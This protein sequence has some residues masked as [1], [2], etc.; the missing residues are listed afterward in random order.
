MRYLL[1]T[2][3]CI[4]LI[5]ER[6]RALSEAIGRHRPADV[7]LSVVTSYE[8]HYGAYRSARMKQNM[9]ALAAFLRPFTIVAF[10]TDDAIK[11]GELRAELER[12]GTPI[13]PYDLLIAAQAA[14]RNVTLVTN[15]VREFARVPG[16]KVEDW[17]EAAEESK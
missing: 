12:R 10:S 8:L 9:Q 6:S 17:T 3:I 11:A 14:T 13:G 1:D 15:N 7:G 4:F 2:N 5:R 16:L